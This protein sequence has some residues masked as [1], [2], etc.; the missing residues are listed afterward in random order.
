MGT[1]A[2]GLNEAS[3]LVTRAFDFDPEINLREIVLVGL[4][5]TGSQL[6]RSVCRTLFD[7]KMRNQMV[8]RLCLVDPD[9]VEMKNVGRQMFAVADVGHFKAEVL[10]RRF[11]AALGLNIRFHADL[12]Q[13]SMAYNG[14]YGNNRLLLGAVD[15]HEARCA[16]ADCGGLWIDC[17]NHYSSGQVVIGNT[18]S[19]DL[20]RHE[21]SQPAKHP[22]LDALSDT[23][24]IRHL[25]T[26]AVLFPQLLEPPEEP[27]PALSCAELVEIGEQHLLVN[28]LVADVAAQYVYRLL[29]R[30]PIRS[31]MTYIDTDLM[32]VRSVPIT[33]A[34]L[35][36]R[37]PKKEVA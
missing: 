25:P 12:F 3:V 4:G 34:E 9:V 22:K 21:M 28:D 23:Y 35:E 11:S 27:E 1:P 37:L 18:K 15:N 33:R 31:F 8:P 16:L 30:Q 2:S 14:G 32:N 6:V 7:M 17:G 13:P 5:G 36:Y 24:T 10:A 29:H 19:T 26:A 20:I